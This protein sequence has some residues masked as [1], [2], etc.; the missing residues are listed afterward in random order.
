MNEFAICDHFKWSLKEL[1][2]LSLKE[3]IVLTA[4]FKKLE[5][6]RKKIERK[7]KSKGKR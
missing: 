4:Y 3:Y 2:K 6:E 1:R 5:R 7:M